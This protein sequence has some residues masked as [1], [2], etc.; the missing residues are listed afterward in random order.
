[1]SKSIRNLPV[2]REIP[3]V[4]VAGTSRYREVLL[5]SVQLNGSQ[6]KR[7]RAML[8]VFCNQRPQDVKYDGVL[9]LT[10]L[11]MKRMY[12]DFQDNILSWER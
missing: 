8:M 10:D 7:I 2:K 3:F 11:Q 9:G 12:F 4:H 1:M 6:W 5:P